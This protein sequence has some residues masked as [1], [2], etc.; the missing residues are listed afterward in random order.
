MISIWTVY[1]HPRDYPH[2]YVARLFHGEKP[3][4]SVIVSPDLKRLR[5]ILLVDMGLTCMSR[6]SHDD[7]AILETW[8]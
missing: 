1:D 2:S 3:T 8:L 4:H 5:E 7:P 6:S